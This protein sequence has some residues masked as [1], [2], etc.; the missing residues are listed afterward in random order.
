MSKS[1]GN[2]F[3]IRDVLARYHALALRWFLVATHYRAAV[4]YSPRG[5]EEVAPGPG[6]PPKHASDVANMHAC[7]MSCTCPHSKVAGGGHSSSL[8][9]HVGSP[10]RVPLVAA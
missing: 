2:F 10:Q 6:P 5:L 9:A 1:L 4:S 8:S 7:I 3:T